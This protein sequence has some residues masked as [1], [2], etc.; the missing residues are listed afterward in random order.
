MRIGKI[1]HFDA[2]HFLPGYKGKCKRLH[3][4]TYKLEIVVEGRKKKNGMVI[5]FNE[6]KTIVRETVLDRLDHQNMNE[7]FENPTAENMAEWIFDE[8][9]KKIPL[10]SVR[11]WEGRDKWVE[12]EK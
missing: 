6:L 9:N 10:C 11:L 8:L 7:I 1:F 12:I 2:A 3:G 4:H 5:D